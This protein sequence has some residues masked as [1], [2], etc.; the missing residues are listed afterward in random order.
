MKIEDRRDLA[1]AEFLAVIEIQHNPST[2]G[3]FFTPSAINFSSSERS[4]TCAGEFLGSRDEM[5][6][7]ARI[8]AL[9]AA[10]RLPSYPRS[11]SK[12]SW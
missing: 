4:R 2:R 5:D 3:I 12:A 8:L 10:S 7:T 9:R 1:N 11:S 6:E